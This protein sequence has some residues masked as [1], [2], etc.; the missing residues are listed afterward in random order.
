M[1]SLGHP[2]IPSLCVHV[3]AHVCARVCVPKYVHIHIQYV[4]GTAPILSMRCVTEIVGFHFPR[5]TLHDFPHLCSHPQTA[6]THITQ[7]SWSFGLRMPPKRD[8]I[9]LL[10]FRHLTEHWA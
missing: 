4:H 7:V 10:R 5:I 9:T 1:V 2:L 3:C 8:L 6:F